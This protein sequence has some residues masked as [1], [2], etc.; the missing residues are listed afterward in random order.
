MSETREQ[1][2]EQLAELTE[3]MQS[4]TRVHMPEDWPDVELTMPQLRTLALLWDAPRRMGE[5][6]AHIGSS[7]SA[8]TAMIDRL[9]DKGLVERVHDT[10]DRRVV[11]CHLTPL[12]REQIESFWRLGRAKL[13]NVAQF[14]TD[15]QLDTVVHA[16][17]ILAD[18][19]EQANQDQADTDAERLAGG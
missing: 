7:L 13:E 11:T 9:V 14:L 17:K 5:I 4:R 1:R 6:A 10:A 16:M 3:R 2:I 19:V 12:G 15:E 18:A 8:T